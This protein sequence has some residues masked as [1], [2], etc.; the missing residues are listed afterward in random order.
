MKR[1]AL[2]CLLAAL[3]AGCDQKK[4]V[5][6]TNTIAPPTEKDGSSMS[7]GNILKGGAGEST[8]PEKK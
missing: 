8:T 2:V 5:M 4:V 7:G 1:L 3:L 6:P